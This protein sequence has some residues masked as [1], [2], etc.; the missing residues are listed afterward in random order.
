MRKAQIV[1]DFTMIIIAAMIIFLFIFSTINKRNDELSGTRTYLFAKQL[2]DQVA[3]AVNTVHI[4]GD[5]TSREVVLPENLK[6]GTP[7]LITVEPGN[8]AVRIKWYYQ[9][10]QREYSSTILTSNIN[11]SLNFNTSVNLTNVRGTVQVT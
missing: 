9:N 11:G 7:Y 2:A 8:R 1:T 5:G 3:S 10:N 4:A 6:D